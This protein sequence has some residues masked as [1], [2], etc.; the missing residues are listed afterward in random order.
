MRPA[1]GHPDR[2][3]PVTNEDW[4]IRFS[5]PAVTYIESKAGHEYTDLCLAPQS[6]GVGARLKVLDCNG[7]VIQSW[8]VGV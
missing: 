6:P 7:T 4:Y 3:Q 1:A 5:P 8:V 2:L